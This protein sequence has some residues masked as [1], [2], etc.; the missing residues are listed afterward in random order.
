MRMMV[1]RRRLLE[2][3][4]RLKAWR[5]TRL[6]VK[7]IRRHPDSFSFKIRYR[8]VVRTERISSWLMC[9][10]LFQAHPAISFHFQSLL[11]MLV[12]SRWYRTRCSVGAWSMRSSPFTDTKPANRRDKSFSGKICGSSRLTGGRC[13]MLWRVLPQPGVIR[14][15]RV[16][17]G[18]KGT[19]PNLSKSCLSKHTTTGTDQV[20]PSKVFRRSPTHSR[21]RS[22]FRTHCT[23]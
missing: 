3:L 11:G 13:K 5:T 14:A 2:L 18:T 10:L 7:W 1:L 4:P 12:R 20:F 17:I 23:V 22:C 19:K 15:R 8:K 16:E 21:W 6:S 9:S